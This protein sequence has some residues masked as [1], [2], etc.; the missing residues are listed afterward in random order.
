MRRSPPP[1]RLIVLGGSSPIWE[2]CGGIYY[3]CRTGHRY[4]AELAARARENGHDGV[5][6]RFDSRA[7]DAEQNAALLRDLVYRSDGTVPVDEVPLE[8]S[9]Q[10]RRKRPKGIKR[11]G[12][13]GARRGG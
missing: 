2:E 4:S 8:A 5:A 7:A 9:K 13:R 10:P 3:R 6:E 11:R 12:S 1:A